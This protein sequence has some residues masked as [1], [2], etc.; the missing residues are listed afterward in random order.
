LGYFNE[1]MR[2]KIELKQDNS[3]DFLGLN[4]KENK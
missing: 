4:E 2:V 1:K 3:G